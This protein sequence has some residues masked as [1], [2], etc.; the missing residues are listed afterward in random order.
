MSFYLI[1]IAHTHQIMAVCHWPATR[2]RLLVSIN[3][4]ASESPCYSAYL[5][6]RAKR[7]RTDTY[8]RGGGGQLS[9]FLLSVLFATH[10][11]PQFLFDGFIGRIYCR[12]SL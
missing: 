6:T 4:N 3:L 11:F 7:T 8:N 10:K 1:A 12:R 5:P 2:I 9:S